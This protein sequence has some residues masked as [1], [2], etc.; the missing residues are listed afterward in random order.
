MKDE[1]FDNRSMRRLFNE[2]VVIP[3]GFCYI[4]LEKATNPEYWRC[5]LHEAEYKREYYHSKNKTMICKCG[6]V[7]KFN[8]YRFHV[9]TKKHQEWINGE[10]F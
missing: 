2:I 7:I 9:K 4:C 3:N 10:L 5:H 1:N 8:Y 6:A